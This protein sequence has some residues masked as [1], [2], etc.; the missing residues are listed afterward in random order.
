M[1]VIMY[2]PP[3]TDVYISDLDKHTKSKGCDTAWHVNKGGFKVEHFNQANICSH[4]CFG[5]IWILWQ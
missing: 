3:Q 5:K 4:V 2:E 1:V